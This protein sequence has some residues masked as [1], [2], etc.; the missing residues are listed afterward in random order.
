MR[1]SIFNCDKKHMNQCCALCPDLGRC[2]NPCLNHPD[3]CGKLREET[4]REVATAAGIRYISKDEAAQ[5]LDSGEVT[6]KYEPLGRFIRKAGKKFIGIDNR[7]GDAWTEEF[8][9]EAGCV[10]WL[11]E[12]VPREEC[13]P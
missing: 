10:R 4:P 3:R 13:G 5:I 7:D 11:T 12:D 2:K 8:S 1:C 9:T 6:G